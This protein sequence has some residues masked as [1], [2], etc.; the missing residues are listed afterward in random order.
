MSEERALPTKVRQ[1]AGSAPLQLI[2]RNELG[3]ETF[4]AVDGRHI[5]WQPLKN[6]DPE[7]SA[8][9]DL[10][11]E[12]D[13]LRWA[14]RFV[15]VPPV[16]DGGVDEDGAWLVTEAL[17]ATS[18]FDPRWR[19]RPEVAV[20]AIATGLRRLHDTL[21]VDKCPYPASWPGPISAIPSIRTRSPS[22]AG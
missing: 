6:L 1:L 12:A 5:K 2:W 7:R 21:P 13:K 3:G 11:V 20:V 18:A 15:R 22:M 10:V 19:D 14:G 16:L 9:V 8:D 4:R 17:D